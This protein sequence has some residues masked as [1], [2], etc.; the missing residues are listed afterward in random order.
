MTHLVFHPDEV[1]RGREVDLQK[2]CRLP[3]HA[4]CRVRYAGR[5]PDRV[6]GL[7]PRRARR[8]LDV[9]DAFEQDVDILG[10]GVDVIVARD[11]ARAQLDPVQVDR[12]P[13]GWGD[14]LP[15]ATTVPRQ[16]RRLDVACANHLG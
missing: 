11:A 4:S 16:R 12:R 13:V 15:L 2:D 14:E 3:A 6:A 8:M 5:E 1:R 9:E 10:P 7:E